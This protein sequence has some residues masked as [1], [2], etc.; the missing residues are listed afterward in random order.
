M[1]VEILA[2]Y[3]YPTNPSG[4]EPQFLIPNSNQIPNSSLM[5]SWLIFTPMT[6]SRPV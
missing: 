3:Y 2:D 4:F 1:A 6:H 5:A